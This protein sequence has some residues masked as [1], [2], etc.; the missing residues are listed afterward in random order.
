MCGRAACLLTDADIAAVTGDAGARLPPGVQPRVNSAPGG[1][2][3]PLLTAP[4]PG[5]LAITPA[6]WGV[7]GHAGAPG[8]PST[9]LLINARS[10]T[11]TTT[12]TW[13]RL[14]KRD[15]TSRAVALVHGWYEWNAQK[16]PYF[17]H[18]CEAGGEGGDVK[19]Q[20]AP[21]SL[22]ALA[23]L[24]D[25]TA[26]PHPRF[27]ILTT[28]PP[29]HLTWLHDRSPAVLGPAS[30]AGDAASAVRGWLDGRTAPHDLPPY[31]GHLAWHPVSRA[32]GDV[33]FQDEREATDDVRRRGGLMAVWAKAKAR[34]AA[35]EAKA[36]PLPQPAVKAEKS[37]PPKPVP[38]GTKRRA[39][40][41]DAFVI[42]RE[43][44]AG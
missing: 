28:A 3:W 6:V 37:T 24:L 42:K 14:L 15:S 38:R 40:T 20:P 21:R 27:V 2:L 31:T 8:S 32:V 44:K 43:K 17:V 5:H 16:Q 34:G 10:E 1:G 23:A 26:S 9:R 4:A 39:T 36:K 22:L 12:P 33:R 19:A 25:T 29:P 11:A 13:S 35:A 41:L 18:G 30:D 7:P